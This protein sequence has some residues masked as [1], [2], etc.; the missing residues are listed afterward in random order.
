MGA[1][2]RKP[3]KVSSSTERH[4]VKE[5]M[6]EMNRGELFIDINSA[7]EKHFCY[8]SLPPLQSMVS[9]RHI[10][11]FYMYAGYSGKQKMIA[12]HCRIYVVIGFIWFGVFHVRIWP[13]ALSTKSN[14]FPAMYT[15]HISVMESIQ[16]LQRLKDGSKASGAL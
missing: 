5:N 16:K 11:A 14:T 15:Y 8:F 3:V 10:V 6:T 13:T 4:I 1:Y 9:E 7:F 12:R 2:F